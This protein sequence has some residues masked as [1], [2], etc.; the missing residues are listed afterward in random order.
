MIDLFEFFL[1]I[2]NLR[3]GQ[4]KL[5]PPKNSTLRMLRTYK[6]SRFLFFL[7]SYFRSL[8]E[9]KKGKMTYIEKGIIV[10]DQRK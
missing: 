7:I 9:I 8:T 3:E 6:I 4:G 2:E 5:T 10:G 1:G